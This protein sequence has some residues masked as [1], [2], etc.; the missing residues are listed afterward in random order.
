ML[1]IEDLNRLLNLPSISL[2][3]NEKKVKDVIDFRDEAVPYVDNLNIFTVDFVNKLNGIL[4]Y[5]YMLQNNPWIKEKCVIGIMGAYNAGKSTLLNCL[6]GIGLPTGINPVTAV[7][8][9]IAYGNE[10]QHYIV[11]NDGNLK[12]IPED[13]ESRL[14]H[15]ETNGFN[16]R[17]IISHTVLYNQSRFLKKISFLDTPGISADNDYDYETTANAANKCDVVLWAIRAKAG[18]IT[19]FEIEFIKKYISD[20]K[21]YVVITHADK[22][23]NPEKVRQTVLK[24]LNDAKIDCQGSYFFGLRTTHMINVEEEL[25]H[26]TEAFQKEIREFKSFQPQEQLNKYM[27]YIQSNLETRINDVTEEKQRIETV[28]RE[29]ENH[30]GDIKQ[31][32]SN[33]TE[34]LRRSINNLRDTIN[35][36]CRV[37]RFCTGGTDGTYTQLLNHHNSMVQ[38]YNNLVH[39]IA[40]LDI[41]QLV[42]YGKA[43]SYLSRLSDNLDSL[44]GSRN[45]CVELIKKSKT[46]LK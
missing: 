2:N 15:E 20:K 34:S 8:T 41:E 46:L 37:V 27:S 29:Y 1:T 22:S 18:A 44:V 13:L 9:Y 31:S 32:L 26:I 3:I 36:R 5:W 39:S 10:N 30:V 25:Q 45:K 17:K 7:A 28:C 38:N 23:P 14:S 42:Q 11:D 43:V 6:L 12:K 33:N 21:L 19:E 4:S 16:L 24:Q 35:N 40:E